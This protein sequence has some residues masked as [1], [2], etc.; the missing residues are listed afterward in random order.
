MDMIGAERVEAWLARAAASAH[1]WPGNVREL[2]NALRDLLLGLEPQLGVPAKPERTTSRQIPA[3]I[4]DATASLR[5]VE[6]WYLRLVLDRVDRNYAAAARILQTDRAT[7]RRR[8]RTLGI[9]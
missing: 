5:D 3:P 7:V 2:Q 8:A 4:R 9:A 6:D 1:P